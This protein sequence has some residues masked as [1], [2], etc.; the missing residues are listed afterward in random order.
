MVVD[1]HVENHNRLSNR[2]G[3]FGFFLR[4]YYGLSGL[5]G[6]IIFGKRIEIVVFLFFSFLILIFTFLIITLGMLL[7][8]GP[9][10]EKCLTES[11]EEEIP[12]VGVRIFGS[13]GEI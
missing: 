13:V 5:F 7:L 6:S 3:L 4:L 10:V 2:F 12:I 11:A 8:V 9:N 1:F